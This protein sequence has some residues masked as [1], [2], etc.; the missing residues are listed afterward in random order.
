MLKGCCSW[1]TL[2]SGGRSSSVGGTY[3]SRVIPI[4]AAAAARVA[5]SAR[6]AADNRHPVRPDQHG[7]WLSIA[8]APLARLL[9]KAPPLR[10]AA[11]AATSQRL[12]PS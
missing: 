2:G 8:T 7:R 1:K 6:A 3:G 5:A 12:N 4:A 10:S 9:S 11:D